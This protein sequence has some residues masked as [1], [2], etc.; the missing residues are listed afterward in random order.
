VLPL[1]IGPLFA[2]AFAPDGLTVAAGG[3]GG[4]VVIADVDEP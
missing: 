4:Q 3:D 1:G 2:A